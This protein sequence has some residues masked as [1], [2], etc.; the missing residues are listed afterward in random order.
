M[1]LRK[2]FVGKKYN[3]SKTESTE[4]PAIT[5]C[6]NSKLSERNVDKVLEIEKWKQ[7]TASDVSFRNDF[8]AALRAFIMFD[9]KPHY[10]NNLGS[11]VI[12][13][14]DDH[15]DELPEIIKQVPLHVLDFCL[16]KC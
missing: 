4:L 8:H 6:S 12:K 13:I 15:K 14:L 9:T 3:I 10:V 7:Y 11:G 5:L 1:N 2:D 16:Q